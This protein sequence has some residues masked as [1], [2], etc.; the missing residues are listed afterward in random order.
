[1]PIEM[2]TDWWYGNRLEGIG[3]EWERYCK[4]GDI[5]RWFGR[6]DWLIS[7]LMIW[8]IKES[9]AALKMPRSWR[10]PK[11]RLPPD[12]PL[13]NRPSK[14]IHQAVTVMRINAI[15][16]LTRRCEYVSV[17][18]SQPFEFECNWANETEAIVPW[19]GWSNENLSIPTAQWNSENLETRNYRLLVS[20]SSASSID[21]GIDIVSKSLTIAL[22]ICLWRN[23]RVG[24]PNEPI[25]CKRCDRP[26]VSNRK[27]IK[28]KCMVDVIATL[29][30][31]CFPQK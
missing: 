25:R 29:K 12:S 3:D 2:L 13:A 23:F 20:R 24:E 10:L 8:D 27:P 9:V 22:W 26:T 6:V 28:H 7:W 31:G 4:M 5:V 16:H 15:L 18:P 21:D 1:M 30:I 19:A 11:K 14:M 17:D